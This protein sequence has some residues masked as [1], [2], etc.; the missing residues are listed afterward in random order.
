MKP[1][2]N[3]LTD[4]Q[5][6]LR[7]WKKNPVT[8]KAVTGFDGFVD[9]IRK[10]VQSKHGDTVEYYPTLTAFASRI[11][12]ASGKS[13]QVEMVTIKTKLGGNAPIL[14]NALG[15][16][17]IKNTCIGAMGFPRKHK[18]FASMHANCERLSL[19]HP[20]ASDAIEFSD[21]KMI[22][23]DLKVF[24]PY[25]WKYIR[26]C[27]D[28]S[29]IKRRISESALVAFADW[30][31]LPHAYSIWD[32]VLHD[33]IK[34]SGRH[35]YLFLFDLCD[36]TKRTTEDIDEILDLISNF[37]IYGKVTLCLNEN[38]TL[39]IWA[40]L[41]GVNFLSPDFKKHA[42]SLAEAGDFL[43]KMMKIEYLLVHPI[44]R[45]LL[46][47]QREIIESTGILVTECRVMTGGGDNLN[48]GYALGW[49]AGLPMS[50]CLLLGMAASGAYIRNGNSPTLQDLIDYLEW[51]KENLPVEKERLA[52]VQIY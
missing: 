4:L 46:F 49:M 30:A 48:A 15:K 11:Q 7:A 37:S 1:G 5:E 33:I 23:S 10:A 14:S 25:D 42:P 36:V 35:D 43:Y 45:I 20:G 2:R 24:D 6:H 29:K 31:N 19:L 26:Q 12:A 3:T 32:G 9:Q 38:E 16:L 41:N 51:W 18:A 47:H 8:Q 39:A 34:K 50:D 17:E 44:D 21:G 27:K 22:F 13:G 28:F 52:D 40:S